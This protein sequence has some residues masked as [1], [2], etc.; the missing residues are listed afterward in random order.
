[1]AYGPEELGFTS[2]TIARAARYQHGSSIS[3]KEQLDRSIGSKRMLFGTDHPF[4]PPL[5]EGDKWRSVVENLEAIDAVQGWTDADKD[6][7][8]GRNALELFGL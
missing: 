7:V 6:G 1:M 2:D 4:F 8:R 5:G 3:I